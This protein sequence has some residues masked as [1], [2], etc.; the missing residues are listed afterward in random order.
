MPL[1]LGYS[2]VGD[3]TIKESTADGKL[4]GRMLQNRM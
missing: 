4:N 1:S 2:F 3:V